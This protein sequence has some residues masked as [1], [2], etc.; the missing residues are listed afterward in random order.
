V[1]RRHHYAHSAQDLPSV[2]RPHTPQPLGL[3]Q[4]RG[5]QPDDVDARRYV[6]CHRRRWARGHGQFGLGLSAVQPDEQMPLGRLGPDELLELLEARSMISS[7]TLPMS[8]VN[9]LLIVT[10]N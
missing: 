5:R 2:G 7:L 8:A 9:P 10:N 6:G 3:S 4:G 1:L